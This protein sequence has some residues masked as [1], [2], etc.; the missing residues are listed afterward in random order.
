MCRMGLIMWSRIWAW[1]GPIPMCL[2]LRVSLMQ[3]TVRFVDATAWYE[4]WG[5][6]R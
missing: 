2:A 6:K 5:G 3:E 4:D 1:T